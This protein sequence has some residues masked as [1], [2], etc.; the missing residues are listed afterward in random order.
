MSDVLQ[1]I[2]RAAVD[3]MIVLPSGVLFSEKQRLAEF[4]I[5]S[6]LPT[7]FEQREHAV[8]GGL[9]CYGPNLSELYRHAA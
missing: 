2:G 1:A 4:A 9:A 8:A 6:H 3:G 7:M 5:R